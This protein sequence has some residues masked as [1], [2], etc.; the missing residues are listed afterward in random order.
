MKLEIED[1][2]HS[3]VSLSRPEM[4][5]IRQLVAQQYGNPLSEREQWVLDNLDKKVEHYLKEQEV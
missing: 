5:T 1:L 2:F 4:Q 3:F